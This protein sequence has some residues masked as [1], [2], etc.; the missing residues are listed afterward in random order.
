M[1]RKSPTPKV[2]K[3]K[4]LFSRDEVVGLCKRFLKEDAYQ[5]AR[6][7]MVMYRLLKQYPSR[8]FWWHFELG[9]QLNAMFWFL[10]KDGQERLA[11][12][13]ATFSLDMPAQ[14]EYKLEETKVGADVVIDRKPKTVADLLKQP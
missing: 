11:T 12:D 3:P 10:G 13:W 1:A 9:F 14:P 2:P 5:A 4:P 6:D 8:A 7:K